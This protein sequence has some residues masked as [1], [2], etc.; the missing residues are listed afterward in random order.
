[1]RNVNG[2]YL[3]GLGGQA[4]LVLARGEVMAVRVRGEAC[5]VRC[6]TGRLWVTAEGGGTDHVLLPG[7]ERT[8]PGSGKLVIQAMRTAT[9]RVDRRA[10]AGPADAALLPAARVA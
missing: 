3:R 9:V 5:R 2:V 6:V 7:D 8:F 10:V 1:M 4:T